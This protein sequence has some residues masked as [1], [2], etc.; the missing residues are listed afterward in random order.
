[1]QLIHNV[2]IHFKERTN[3]NGRFFCSISDGDRWIKVVYCCLMVEFYVGLNFW[4][5]S[6]FFL[7]VCLFALF[8]IFF[9][10]A[11]SKTTIL[12]RWNLKKRRKTTQH[13]R[14]FCP[15]GIRNATS[16]FLNLVE[17]ANCSGWID[18]ISLRVF[19]CWQSSSPCQLF[20]ILNVLPFEVDWFSTFNTKRCG[21]HDLRNSRILLLLPLFWR[22][23]VDTYRPPWLSVSGRRRR[24]RRNDWITSGTHNPLYLLLLFFLSFQDE[25]FQLPVLLLLLL[26][27]ISFSWRYFVC[28]VMC[29]RVGSAS[30]RRPGS[31]Q[32]HLSH[33]LLLFGCTYV[34]TLISP[35]DNESFS[36]FF[37]IYLLLLL[38]FV[39]VFFFF[40]SF[41]NS[42]PSI[43]RNK[44]GKKM[45]T[46]VRLFFC[47]PRFADSKVISSL[48][49]PSFSSTS[50]FVLA[51]FGNKCFF[52]RIRFDCKD[53][54]KSPFSPADYSV[55]LKLKFKC[56]Q[57]TF[58]RFSREMWTK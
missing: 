28:D 29:V 13:N 3:T 35:S 41:V 43:S 58:D 34:R 33:L 38:R 30:R 37:I 26:L 11:G 56:Q 48:I 45:F 50:S 4:R 44:K 24:R 40:C 12:E 9:L 20:L 21:L 8:F 6:T 32:A 7:C 54:S 18:P 15:Q 36:F 14:E 17:Y 2:T 31:R 22:Y 16:F 39:F 51:H 57:G 25:K 42:F 19:L 52:F 49:V 10:N 47:V 23:M 5:R 55:T 46:C 27:R 53:S 1:M